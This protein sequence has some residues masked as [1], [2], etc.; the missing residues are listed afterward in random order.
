MDIAGKFESHA[1][2]ICRHAFC[3]DVTCRI[4][5]KSNFRESVDFQKNG[6]TSL[7]SK[8]AKKSSVNLSRTFLSQILKTVPS[9]HCSNDTKEVDILDRCGLPLNGG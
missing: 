8:I 7:F 9:R 3:T 2:C 5:F 6:L 1:V 4:N